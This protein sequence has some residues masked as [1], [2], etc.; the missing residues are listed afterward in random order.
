MGTIMIRNDE[1]NLEKV[2]ENVKYIRPFYENKTVYGELN[3]E[4]GSTATFNMNDYEFFN[5][6]PRKIER[7]DTN[8]L[9]HV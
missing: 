2:Y 6:T 3:F 7:F 9:Y 5:L 1:L 4:D 8:F